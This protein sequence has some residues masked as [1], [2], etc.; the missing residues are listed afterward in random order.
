M[1]V[2]KE[3][4]GQSN[5]R[6]SYCIENAQS[7]TLRLSPFPFPI[8]SLDCFFCLLLL[9][10]FT[11]T[12]RHQCIVLHSCHVG[13]CCQDQRKVCLVSLSQENQKKVR[14]KWQRRLLLGRGPHWGCF[15]SRLPPF[16]AVAAISIMTS[17]QQPLLLKSSPR[18]RL[19]CVK[20]I[21]CQWLVSISEQERKLTGS[22]VFILF[23]SL[24]IIFCLKMK[25]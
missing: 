10:L 15:S 17:Q 2:N 24:K 8:A 3:Q 9:P 16:V 5:P 25:I 19:T 23:L 6:S 22:T 7:T 11:S 14:K 12:K 13:W 4:R 20:N 21:L 1:K 18:R